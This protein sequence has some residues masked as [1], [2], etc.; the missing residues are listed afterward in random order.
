MMSDN[1]KHAHMNAWHKWLLGWLDPGQLRGVTS[2]T[3]EATIT[4]LELSG[5][6][7][8]VVVPTDS[9]HAYVIEV[10]QRIGWDAPLCDKGVLV[11]YVDGTKYNVQGNAI[12]QAARRDF[13]EACGA[14]YDAPFDLGANEISTFENGS[15]KVEIVEALADGSYRVRVTKK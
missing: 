2:G 14:I 13:S 3:A 12:V 4:P 6:V 5:G 10:R 11:W 1:R 15:V 7:K 8:A 9:S